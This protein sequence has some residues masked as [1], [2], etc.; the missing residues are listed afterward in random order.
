MLSKFGPYLAGLWEGDGSI[1]LPKKGHKPS[2]HITLHITQSPLA[3]KL[4]SVIEKHSKGHTKVGS[5]TLRKTSN[6]CNLNIY[7][8]PGLT[9][10]VELVNGNLKTPKAY[11]ISYII[12][13]LHRHQGC[14]IKPLP[15]SSIPLLTNAWLTGFIDADG[16]FGIIQTS[17][18]QLT[19]RQVRL[20][21][22]LNQR[23]NYPK[24]NESY[25]S[26]MSAICSALG[27]N[28][29]TIQEKKSGRY[30]YVVKATSADSK[31][32][33]RSYLDTFPLLSSKYY[34]YSDWCCVDEFIISKTQFEQ[35]NFVKIQGIKSKM[36]LNRMRFNWTHLENF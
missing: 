6:A 16:S 8:I 32:R 1:K 17:K 9:M 23:R 13:W 36:N 31:K 5:V 24:Q 14:I 21:F 20:Q 12:D 15:I 25:S 7:S 18:T 30:Y 28:L 27:V 29:H 11:Q 3:K 35:E 33:L 26:V 22:Q 4:L 10:F 2:I 19:K 34:D